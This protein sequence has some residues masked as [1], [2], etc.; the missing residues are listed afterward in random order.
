MK[1]RIPILT[2]QESREAVPLKFSAA[3]ARETASGSDSQGARS[4]DSMEVDPAL[5]ITLRTHAPR[6][7]AVASEQVRKALRPPWWA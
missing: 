7:A 4:A 2:W 3:N 1:H 6:P 5:R